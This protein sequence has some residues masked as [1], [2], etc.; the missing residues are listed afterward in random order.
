MNDSKKILTSILHIVQMGQ[1]GIEAV[2]NKAVKPEMEKLLL[3]QMQDYKHMES[4]A[5]KLSNQLGW[6]LPPINVMTQKMSAY[7]AKCRLLFGDT[8]STIAAMLVQGNTRGMILGL[9][10][11]H[12]A[13]EIE[14]SVHQLANK[15]LNMEN[16]NIQKAREYL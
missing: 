6:N 8:D 9:K 5:Q 13:A 15:L 14:P 3:E 2:R 7:S 4:Q 1:S 10:D 11:L 16:L 12:Q